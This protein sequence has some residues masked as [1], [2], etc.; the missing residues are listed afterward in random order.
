MDIANKLQYDQDHGSYTLPAE[1]NK[2]TLEYKGS[3]INYVSASVSPNGRWLA[4]ITGDNS[5]IRYDLGEDVAMKVGEKAF[6]WVGAW[7]M[8]EAVPFIDNSGETIGFSGR[9]NGLWVVEVN[10]QCLE[11]SDGRVYLD[12]SITQF[13]SSCPARNLVSEIY[14]YAHPYP[15]GYITFDVHKISADGA[16][17]YYTDGTNWQRISY[18][19]QPLLQ[20][21]ALGDS[22]ASGEGDMTH[23]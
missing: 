9:Q 15:N 8:P 18:E 2:D 22:F 23:G 3:P 12:P 7:P 20:Y 11:A 21:L 16:A 10:R 1:L 17:I 5:L 14:E 19:P 4:I 13:I 6:S